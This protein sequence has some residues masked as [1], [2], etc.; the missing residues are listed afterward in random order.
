MEGGA[1]HAAER[2]NRAGVAQPRGPAMGIEQRN[3]RL[4]LYGARRVRGRVVKEYRG[5]LP[6]AEVEYF[7]GR[8]E[9][10]R[11]M[12]EA[13]WREARAVGALADAVLAAG[14]G[15]DRLADR[16][17]RVVMILT[18]HRLHRRADWRRTRG[19]V[20]MLDVRDLLGRDR[21]PT[22]A[23]IKPTVKDP[24][25]QALLDRAAAGDQTAL[26]VVRE[27]LKEH[28]LIESWGAVGW[29]AESALITAA[30]GDDVVVAEA[31]RAKARE[32]VE[33]L[34]ADG[35]APSYPERL[36]ATRAMHAWLTVHILETLAARYPPAGATAAALDKRV[37]QADRRLN[38][39]LKALETIRRL[40][41][42]TGPRQVNVSAGPM[43]VQNGSPTSLGVG[44]KGVA[45]SG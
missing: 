40:R 27:L 35:P 16:V 10:A 36:L 9:D 24:A 14:A 2:G 15:F 38:A 30:A 44:P 43:L 33:Q 3:G 34:L 20:P 39:S 17:F 7:R 5:P 45:G 41:R 6:A 13:G 11:A 8:A 12:R 23:L 42:P 1:G 21:E 28:R 26:P 31:M 19:A 18:G 37:T 22:A 29:W 4:Y 25:T 32:Y